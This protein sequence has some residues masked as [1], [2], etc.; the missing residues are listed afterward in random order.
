MGKGSLR[1]EFEQIAAP[2]FDSWPVFD[3][4]TPIILIFEITSISPPLEQNGR[5]F[6]KSLH[7]SFC[8]TS[9]VIHTDGCR[10]NSLISIFVRVI[11]RTKQSRFSPSHDA[12]LFEKCADG[13]LSLHARPRTAVILQKATRKQ[14]RSHYRDNS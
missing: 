7:R 8:G 14:P 5:T 13:R 2:F 6:A 12:I 9:V 3:G 11:M 4:P 10:R 1:T